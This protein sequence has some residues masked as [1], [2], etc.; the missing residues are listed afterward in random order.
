MTVDVAIVGAGPTGLSLAN[1]LGAAGVGTVLLERNGHTAAE[2]RAV[3][4]DDETMR[5][6]QAMGLSDTLFPLLRE[7]RATRY[8]ASPHARVPFAEVNPQGREYGWP[9]RLRVHQPDLERV[10][11]DGLARFASVQVARA[12]PQS[13]RAV[14]QAARR[15]T[16]PA[17][18]TGDS[19]ARDRGAGIAQSQPRRLRRA[20]RSAS[21]FGPRG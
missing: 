21:V 16:L 4:I 12:R 6:F 15:G 2:P 9:K 1:L 11:R 13:A 20:I 14:R 8:F 18:S 17:H 10:L 19:R 3:I 5:A 7:G